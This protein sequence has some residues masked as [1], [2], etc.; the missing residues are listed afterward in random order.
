MTYGWT[1]V[2][3]KMDGYFP[4]YKTRALARAVAKACRQSWPHPSVG[5]VRSP[6]YRG[7]IEPSREE[8]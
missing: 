4:T 1:V 3:N 7:Y 5:V 2:F 8:C 6:G